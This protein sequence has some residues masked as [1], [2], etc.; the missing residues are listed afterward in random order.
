MGIRFYCPN[1]HKL[2]VKTFLAGKRGICPKCGE[3]FEI[4]L[5]SVRAPGERMPAGAAVAET[6][7]LVGQAGA[8]GPPPIPVASGATGPSL[9]TADATPTSAQPAALPMVRPFSPLN[10]VGSP[11]F[12]SA[13]FP[14]GAAGNVAAMP[15]GAMRMG[16]AVATPSPAASAADPIAESPAA[17]WYVRPASGGQFGPAAGDIMRQWLTQRR[18]GA[19]SM[20]WR[21]GWPEWKKASVVFPSLG[22]VTPVAAGAAAPQG[23]AASDFAVD[24]DWVEAIIDT[25]PTVGHLPTNLP[26]SRSKG[27]QSNTIVIVSFFLILLCVLLA[28]VMATVIMRQGNDGNSSSANEPPARA[29]IRLADRDVSQSALLVRSRANT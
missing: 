3:K 18:V 11:G 22:G 14:S 19:D 21:E 15:M 10:P 13:A 16:A 28:I 2:N 5:E 24:D 12:S 1:G 8:S 7:L 4:P 20:V 25:K 27:K 6:P 26:H 9:S 17:I 29:L 23:A